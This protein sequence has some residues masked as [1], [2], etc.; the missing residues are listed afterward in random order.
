MVKKYLTEE[1]AQKYNLFAKNYDIA[2]GAM[3]M[4]IGKYRRNLLKSAK[5]KVLEVGAG[6]GA[7]LR[8]YPS[9]CK[10]TLLDA[11]NEMLNRA[12]EKAL[13]S[14]K[15][16]NC[17]IGN[18]EHLPFPKQ[19]FDIVVDTLCIC[20]YPNPIQALKEM[21]RVCK[22]NGKILLLE[23]GLSN[24]GFLRWLQMKAKDRQLKKLGCHVDRNVNNLMKKAKLRI[25]K[26]Y[27]K[28]FGIIYVIEARP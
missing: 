17:I 24:N 25:K 9:E 14:G 5:G 27:R 19:S 6:T 26:L 12:R 1:I 4:L 10:I 13:K 21:K 20:T 22:K 23:H 18:T 16:I 28:F 11:S 8:Y 15:E 2:E 7:N 3:N